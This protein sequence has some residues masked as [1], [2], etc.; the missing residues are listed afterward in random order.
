MRAENPHLASNKASIILPS[1]ALPHCTPDAL[2]EAVALCEPVE[3]VVALA[4]RPNE[5]AKGIDVVFALDCPA[6]LVDLGD[7]DLD[8]GV[9]LG[10]DD[11]IGSAALARDV[12]VLS[13]S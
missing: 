10:F 11:S 8:R 1:L 5:A 12:A 4:H 3:L 13:V 7:G 6:V 2:D 9:V